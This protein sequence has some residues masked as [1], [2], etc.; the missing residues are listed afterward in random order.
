VSAGTGE[1]DGVDVGPG[2][3]PAGLDDAGGAGVSR[4]LAA[5]DAG[6][7]SDGPGSDGCSRAVEAGAMYAGEAVM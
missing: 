5:T 7:E 4:R 2:K 6:A 1:S 3:P